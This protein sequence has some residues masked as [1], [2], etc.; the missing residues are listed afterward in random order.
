MNCFSK[1]IG[2]NFS[3]TC[4]ILFTDVDEQNETN[5]INIFPN[6]GKD[7]IQILSR[8]LELKKVLIKNIFWKENFRGNYITNPCRIDI[9]FL[10]SGLYFLIIETKEGRVIKKFVKD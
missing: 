4:G 8:E 9:S 2:G 3:D 7:E 1:W 10:T 5:L 6:P